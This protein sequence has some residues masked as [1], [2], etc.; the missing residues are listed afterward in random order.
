ML[1]ESLAGRVVRRRLGKGEVVKE[2][3]CADGV[4]YRVDAGMRS[5]DP[6][7]NQRLFNGRS[8]PS[9][10]VKGVEWDGEGRAEENKSR[11]ISKFRAWP[12]LCR[13][14]RKMC[15]LMDGAWV[16]SEAK[17]MRKRRGPKDPWQGM[18][19]GD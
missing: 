11:V 7:E 19:G 18:S 8:R 14:T 9:K 16:L 6:E 4:N 5:G 12:S 15:G 3:M 10:R 1:A 13:P 2:R 17:E